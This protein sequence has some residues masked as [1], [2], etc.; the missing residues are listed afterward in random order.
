MSPVLELAGVSKDY[1]GLRPLRI[2][3][4]RVAAGEPVA[5][6]GFDQPAAEVFLNLVTGATLPDAGHVQLFGRPTTAIDGGADWLATVDRFGIVSERAVLLEQ[7][8]VVQNLAMPFT[9]DIE[10]PSE[11]VRS[12]AEQL[13]REVGLPAAM[14]TRPVAELDDVARVRV[15]L[16][17]AL[18]FD[19][20]VL[21]LEHVSAGLT[22]AEAEE[23]GADL[24]ALA[25]RRGVAIVAATADEDF[26]GAVAARVLTL[27]PATGRFRDQ[28]R[29]RWFRRRLG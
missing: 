12:R 24:R 14:W 28:R 29:P 10:P 23:L 3:E 16:G 17:R 19:P 6:L 27:D 11:D 4:L 18:A 9:L 13:A 2:H 20:A 15:R 25:A 1:R 5:L 22:K 8:T 7:L 21:L 26:A